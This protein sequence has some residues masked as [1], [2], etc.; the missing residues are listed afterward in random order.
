MSTLITEEPDDV[1]VT[2]GSVGGA[3]SNPRLYPEAERD[4]SSLIADVIATLN[5][6]CDYKGVSSSHDKQANDARSNVCAF[7]LY[8]NGRLEDV[9]QK[10]GNGSRSMS[11]T[12]LI[13]SLAIQPTDG[14]SRLGLGIEIVVLHFRY[15]GIAALSMARSSLGVCEA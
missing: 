15:S 12:Y 5:R 14:L 11:F 8:R 6:Q 2:S 4:R 13:L 1:W 9:F 10:A 3:G 7:L